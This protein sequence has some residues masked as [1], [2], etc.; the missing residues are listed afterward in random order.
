[1]TSIEGSQVKQANC[2]CLVL[3]LRAARAM[4]I[5]DVKLLLQ[6]RDLLRGRNGRLRV[7]WL[8]HR[9]IA[10]TTL[11]IASFQA[12]RRGKLSRRTYVDEWPGP[13]HTDWGQDIER[14]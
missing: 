14:R 3:D 11:Q 4:Q 5:Y 9:E 1:M 12:D 7:M 2:R 10:D 13:D 8:W 6:A